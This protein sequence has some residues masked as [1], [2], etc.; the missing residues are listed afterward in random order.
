MW[1]VKW[2]FAPIA[3]GLVIVLSAFCLVVIDNPTPTPE[4][5]AAS[6]GGG[7]SGGNKHSTP[8]VVVDARGAIVYRGR[9]TVSSLRLGSRPALRG[10]RAPFGLIIRKPRR[11]E[12]TTVRV[13]DSVTLAGWSPARMRGE[14]FRLYAGARVGTRIAE[15]PLMGVAQVFATWKVRGAPYSGEFLVV[16]LWVDGKAVALDAV[17]VA[18]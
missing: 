11:K 17:R 1:N 2:W 14:T 10:A 8:F 13:G 15:G 12:A 9:S 5:R 18:H 7:H 4:F 6:T 3:L 16:R